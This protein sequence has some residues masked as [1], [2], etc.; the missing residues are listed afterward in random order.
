MLSASLDRVYVP[1]PLQDFGYGAIIAA[2]SLSIRLS[3]L[4]L[5]NDEVRSYPMHARARHMDQ[6]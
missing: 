3:C 2:P 6:I 1:S 5:P 4:Y